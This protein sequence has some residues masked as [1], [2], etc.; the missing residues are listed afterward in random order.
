MILFISAGFFA[1]FVLALAKGSFFSIFG[2]SLIVALASVFVGGFLGFLFGIPKVLQNAN[3]A[4]QENSAEK[5]VSNTNLEQISDWLTKIIVGISLTQMPLLRN[6]FAAL[7]SNLSEG[8]SEEFGNADFSY[9]YSCSLL[10]FYSVCGFILMYLWARTHLL[11]QLDNLRR[12]LIAAD[13]K[14]AIAQ[15]TETVTNIDKKVNDLGPN[16]KKAMDLSVQISEIRQELAEFEKQR[17]I[18]QIAESKDSTIQTIIANAQPLPMTV[19]DD[20]QKNRWG[21]QHEF[22]NYILF[23]EYTHYPTSFNFLVQVT[24]QTKDPN[25]SPLNGDVFFML[26]TSYLDPIVKVSPNGNIAIHSFYSTEAF[27]VGV[28]FNNGLKLELDLNKDPKVP[29]EYKYE[30]K[31]PTEDEM[32]NQL[33]KL[34]EELAKI[35]FFN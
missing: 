18:L 10:L 20:G 11:V 15:N 23:A 34:E 17:K 14:K 1:V 8:F 26:H 32:K 22:D 12:Q 29:P 6:E 28:V 24:L 2:L 19:L 21:S 30:E 13:I 7:A 35:Q 27:T 4:G 31:L 25:A 5:I 33:S 9:A 3:A 16:I